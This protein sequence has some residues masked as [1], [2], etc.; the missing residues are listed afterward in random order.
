MRP[1][2]WE[3]VK[4]SLC[5]HCQGIPDAGIEPATCDTCST[6]PM[7]CDSKGEVLVDAMLE[8]LKKEGSYA[9]DD[10]VLQNLDKLPLGCYEEPVLTRKGYLVFIEDSND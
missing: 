8:A 10:G 2:G 4:Q 3:K 7:V 5:V 1:E 9:G 6:T